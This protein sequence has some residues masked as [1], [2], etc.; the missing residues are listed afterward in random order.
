MTETYMILMK[1]KLFFLMNGEKDSK[2]LVFHHLWI[3]QRS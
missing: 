1:K 2:I 3:A